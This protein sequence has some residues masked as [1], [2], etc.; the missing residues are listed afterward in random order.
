MYTRAQVEEV[1]RKMDEKSLE[2]IAE[3]NDSSDELGDYNPHTEEE[4]EER[5]CA[6]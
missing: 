5:G 6:R 2:E 4:D 1:K 3:E